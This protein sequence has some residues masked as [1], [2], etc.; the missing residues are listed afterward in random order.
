MPIILIIS[1]IF[2]YFVHSTIHSFC[3]PATGAGN[4]PGTGA[5]NRRATG[6]GTGHRP[7]YTGPAHRESATGQR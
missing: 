7:Q 5:G 3:V 4:R 1:I 2:I 6:T